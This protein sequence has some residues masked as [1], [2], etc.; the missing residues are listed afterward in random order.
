MLKIILS[1]IKPDMIVDMDSLK[2]QLESMKHHEFG[3]D[4]IK[5]LTRMQNI[6]NTLKM[7]G[8]APDSYHCY[9]YLALKTGP[10]ADFNNIMD[11]IIDD[12]KLGIGFN[13]NITVE[14]LILRLIPSTTTWWRTS[15]GAT[16][17]LCL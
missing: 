17:I 8:H 10:N 5:M 3:N 1:Q 15:P 13:K 2:A 6:Y 4:M 11:R 9:V 16:L 7:N 14:E 12:I